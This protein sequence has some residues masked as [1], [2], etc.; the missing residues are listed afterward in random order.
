MLTSELEADPIPDAS[1]FETISLSEL[2][3]KGLAPEPDPQHPVVLVVDDERVIADT[4]GMIL[5]NNGFAPIIAYS[6]KSALAI[7]QVIPPDL[8]ISDVLMPG[9]SGIEL[10]IK[11]KSQAPDCRVLLFS[12]QAAA[13]D[14]LAQARCNG[15]QFNVLAKPVHP[16]E[17]LTQ[18][19]QLAA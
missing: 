19:A 8:L 13:K 2:T 6:G 14:L 16:D 4:L 1:K 7:A 11:L 17:L 15:H 18:L 3:S 9:I 10:A 12:G 5:R